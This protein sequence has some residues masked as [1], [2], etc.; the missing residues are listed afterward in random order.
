MPKGPGRVFEGNRALARHSLQ[1]ELLP[2]GLLVHIISV[3]ARVRSCS[4]C[5]CI[6]AF[7]YAHTHSNAWVGTR[8]HEQTRTHTCTSAGKH[9]QAP[10]LPRRGRRRVRVTVAVMVC[11]LLRRSRRGIRLRRR[12]IVGGVARA[13]EDSLMRV[14]AYLVALAVRPCPCVLKTGREGP[15]AVCVHRGARV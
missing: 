8:A 10:V 1:R 12:R 5:L 15:E 14:P 11:A 2:L 13:A 3:S 9:R 7:A 4:Y 6:R